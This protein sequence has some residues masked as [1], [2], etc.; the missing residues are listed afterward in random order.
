MNASRAALAWVFGSILYLA[1]LYIPVAGI[2]L[3]PILAAAAI[4][5]ARASPGASAGLALLSAATGYAIALAY[6]GGLAGLNLIAGIGGGLVLLVVLS[7]H[8]VTPALLG[9]LVGLY[10]YKKEG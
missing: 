7:Y 6:T 5:I 4:A 1:S 10:A 3:A 2:T 8:I 9:Y